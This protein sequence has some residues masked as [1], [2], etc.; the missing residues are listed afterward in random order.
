MSKWMGVYMC[1]I[2]LFIDSCEVLVVK[3]NCK[4]AGILL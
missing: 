4:K 3:L 2:L 1:A